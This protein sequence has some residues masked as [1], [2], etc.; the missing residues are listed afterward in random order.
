MNIYTYFN[1][2]K[3]NPRFGFGGK[4]SYTNI[5]N[6]IHFILFEDEWKRSQIGLSNWRD[7]TKGKESKLLFHS[8]NFFLSLCF[9]FNSSF[10]LSGLFSMASVYVYVVIFLWHLPLNFFRFI[11]KFFGVINFKTLRLM[12]PFIKIFNWLT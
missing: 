7:R 3:I 1:T 8:F 9:N 12:F 5:C 4:F 10:I 6:N 2:I 11:Y